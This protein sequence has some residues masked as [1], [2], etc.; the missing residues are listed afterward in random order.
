MSMQLL[1]KGGYE[2]RKADYACWVNSCVVSDDVVGA[3]EALIEIQGRGVNL[4]EASEEQCG[5]TWK[6]GLAMQYT[7]AMS[8]GRSIRRLDNVYFA[9]VDLV[10]N[11]FKVPPLILNAVIMAAGQTGHVD[12]AFATFGEYESLFGSV[13]DK[14]AYNA[15]LWSVAKT[16]GPRL[17]MDTLFNV[18]QDMEDSGFSPDG[19]S[20]STMLEAM[21]LT[22][23]T[24]EDNANVHGLGDILQHIENEGMSVDSRGLRRAAMAAAEVGDED[25]SA[26]AVKLLEMQ[27]GKHNVPDFFYTRLKEI[28]VQA[29]KSSSSSSSK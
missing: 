20:F 11:D 12:R 28:N 2:P 16:R 9:L 27:D 21:C 19:K 26:Q 22:N 17:P 3:V 14:H 29:S 13:P 5:G 1:E 10:R 24:M 18:L 4:L 15:L 6:G 25:T 8:L 23:G 7:I